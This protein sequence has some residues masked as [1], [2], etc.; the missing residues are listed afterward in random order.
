MLC[1]GRKGKTGT[2]ELNAYLQN[3]LNP[4]DKSKKEIKRGAQIFREGDKVMQIKNNYDICWNR[5][6][7]QG[8]GVFNGDIGKIV[9][10]DKSEGSIKIVY[11]DKVAVYSQDMLS[12]LEHAYAVTVHKSQGSE[13][14]AV[15]MPVIG[16]YDKLYYRN[17]LYTAVTRAKKILVIVGSKNR[18]KY[19]IDNNVKTLRYTGLKYYLQNG[20]VF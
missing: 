4:E 15:I 16:G 1:P 9:T 12:E 2:A 20:I 8:L 3:V 17:L 13:F 11:D 10:I 5:S 6:G 7:E 14:P 19:M 18:L